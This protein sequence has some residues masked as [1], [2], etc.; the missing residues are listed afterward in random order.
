M[1]RSALQQRKPPTYM[2]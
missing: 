1:L 2:I